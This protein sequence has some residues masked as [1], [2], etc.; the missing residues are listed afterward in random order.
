MAS[1]V[2]DEDQQRLSRRTALKGLGATAGVGVA[3]TAPQILSAPA[4]SAATVPHPCTDCAGDP[5]DDQTDC[6]NDTSTGLPCS[7]GQNVG[8]G[9]SCT[10]NV[11]CSDLQPCTDGTTCGPGFACQI[12]C[13]G[14][15]LCFPLC[16]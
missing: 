2:G 16:A 6:G 1:D 14:V 12:G 11:P 13:C 9:C 7:C 5:C 15:A 10:Q 3:W 4:A 8:G